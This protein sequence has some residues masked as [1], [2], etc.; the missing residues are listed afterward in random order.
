M[1]S[2]VGSSFLSAAT[3]HAIALML[4]TGHLLLALYK[5]EILDGSSFYFTNCQV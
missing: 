2:A 3:S 4:C 1:K 5:I